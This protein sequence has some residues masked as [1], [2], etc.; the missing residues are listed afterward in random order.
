[1]NI[2][3]VRL[4]DVDGLSESLSP[5]V[6]RAHV[7]RGYDDSQFGYRELPYPNWMGKSLEQSAL[8]DG[9]RR[10]QAPCECLLWMWGGPSESGVW[11]RC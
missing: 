9:G 1:M 6:S 5:E 11:K 8:A 7:R 2:R 3:Q 10:G 4:T